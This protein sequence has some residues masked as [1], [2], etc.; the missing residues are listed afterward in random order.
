MNPDYETLERY[1]GGEHWSEQDLPDDDATIG[2]AWASDPS[3]NVP[4]PATVPAP[5]PMPAPASSGFDFSKA[6][7]NITGAAMAVLQVQSAYRAS[8]APAVRTVSLTPAGFTKTANSDGTVTVR[9]AAG[10]VVGRERPEPGVPYALPDNS[11]ILNNGDGTYTVI[12]PS[13]VRTVR[14]YSAGGVT[15]PDGF[16]SAAGMAIGALA[17]VGLAFWFARSRR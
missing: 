12:N 16:G 6:V 5:V 15:A 14:R 2:D 1:E 9:D 10:V 7:A 3:L 8:R 13:G 17:L 11:V 4:L